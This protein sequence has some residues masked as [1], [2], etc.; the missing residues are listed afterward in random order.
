[1]PQYLMEAMMYNTL[2]SLDKV[3]QAFDDWRQQQPKRCPIP[4]YAIWQS[5]TG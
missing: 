3:K 1:M 2:D 5:C 4:T